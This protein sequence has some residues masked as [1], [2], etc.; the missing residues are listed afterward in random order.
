MKVKINQSDAGGK[1]S[2]VCT[3][4]GEIV[5]GTNIRFH[6]PKSVCERKLRYYECDC[7][8]VDMS[9]DEIEILVLKNCI[10]IEQ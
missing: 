9:E 6:T 2:V 7:G 5:L 10:H 8:A 1:Y 3:G 4:C